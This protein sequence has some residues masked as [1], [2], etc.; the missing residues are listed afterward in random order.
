LAEIF[1]SVSLSFPKLQTYLWF[2]HSTAI[3]YLP[4]QEHAFTAHTILL[5]LTEINSTDLYV[6]MGFSHIIAGACIA[7]SVRENK[8]HAVNMNFSSVILKEQK[9]ILHD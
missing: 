6:Y 9:W 8:R 3:A 7:P 4:F 5:N 2:Q 1:T